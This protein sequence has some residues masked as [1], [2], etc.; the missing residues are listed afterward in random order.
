[1]LLEL[2]QLK[3]LGIKPTRDFTMRDSL[4]AIR[5]EVDTHRRNRE[6][7]DGVQSVGDTLRMLVAVILAVNDSIGPVL[8]IRSQR[9][10]DKWAETLEK[11]KAAQEALYHRW[12][13]PKR[14]PISSPEFTL[15]MA[16]VSIVVMDLISSKFGGLLQRAVD[17]RPSPQPQPQPQRGRDAAAAAAFS[18]AEGGARAPA[19]PPFVPAHF[20][21]YAPSRA[22]QNGLSHWPRAHGY[23]YPDAHGHPSG[24]PAP[25]LFPAGAGHVPAYYDPMPPPA[26]PAGFWA[27]PASP[28]PP[29]PSPYARSAAGPAAPPFAAPPAPHPPR[30]VSAAPPAAA[31][32]L[33]GGTAARHPSVPLAAS[34]GPTHV[35]PDD[36]G[37]WADT[38]ASQVPSHQQPPVEIRPGGR[39][40]RRIAPLQRVM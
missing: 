23:A 18:A 4:A 10:S 15:G 37:G 22:F 29:L 38:A 24:E 28:P 1:L 20:A 32:G 12:F 17:S 19:A 27:G 36:G 8:P 11:H 40:V 3:M 5:W 39:K 14:G 13:A 31:I 26:A 33:Q 30:S 25:P 34:S 9:I 35:A 16:F 7:A 2:E 6:I 21:H